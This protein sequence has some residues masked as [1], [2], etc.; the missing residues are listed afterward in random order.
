MCWKSV[1]IM[2]ENCEGIVKTAVDGWA[3]LQNTFVS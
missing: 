1:R 2:R 3:E